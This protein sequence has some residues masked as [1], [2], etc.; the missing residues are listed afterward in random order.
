MVVAAR[1]DVRIPRA[2]RWAESTVAAANLRDNLDGSPVVP[3]WFPVVR[4]PG[5]AHAVRTSL[6]IQ[7]AMAQDRSVRLLRLLCVGVLAAL[8]ASS[9]AARPARPRW[10]TLP[11]P[12]AMPA[13]ESDGSVE[14]GGAKIFYALYGKGDPVVLLHGGL[15]NSA[16][17]GFQLPVLVDRFQVIA[18][19]SRGQGRSTKGKAAITYD[20]MAADVAGGSDDEDT[21]HART[22]YRLKP[23]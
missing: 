18:I 5:A 16:H 23:D 14:V 3:R 20:Q 19:D 2:K 4:R 9:A 10:Q 1:P 21:I 12:P 13:A 17:F 22:S 8:V 7:T 6:A 15:G 11:M